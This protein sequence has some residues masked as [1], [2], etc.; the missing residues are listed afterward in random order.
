M[1]C[2]STLYLDRAVS[3]MPISTVASSTSSSSSITSVTTSAQSPTGIETSTST[4][5]RTTTQDSTSRSSSTT[6][7]NNTTTSNSRSTTSGSSQ[8][9][10][11][12]EPPFGVSNTTQGGL[13]S[14][15]SGTAEYK[16]KSVGDSTISSTSAGASITPSG[17]EQ[18]G[19][20]SPHHVSKTLAIAL[21][22]I[23]VAFSV[24]AALYYYKARKRRRLANLNVA[25]TT[26]V[27][28]DDPSTPPPALTQDSTRGSNGEAKSEPHVADDREP[29]TS[30]AEPW[31]PVPRQSIISSNSRSSP[32]RASTQRRDVL[33]PQNES[34]PSS[35]QASPY[36]PH[37]R[38][39][40]VSVPRPA[41]RTSPDVHQTPERDLR[42]RRLHPH[43]PPAS[44]SYDALIAAAEL[45]SRETA[46]A[47]GPSFQ[48]PAPSPQ[49]PV[50]AFE[51]RVVI[52]S[53]LSATGRNDQ[54]G[55]IVLPWPL[56]EQLLSFLASTPRSRGAVDESSTNLGSETLPAYAP[57]E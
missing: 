25:S 14:S 1:Y 19:S 3:S 47:P 7:S 31:L 23:P 46:V 54:D 9:P 11:T 49:P 10:A 43:N 20:S 22:I 18:S 15:T 2:R 55:A 41:A 8:P 5:P 40:T 6:T 45:A 33:A 4:S 13:S 36:D 26:C 30:D 32:R 42:Q 56:G 28:V 16:S 21:P 52:E 38:A 50:S 39:S 48:V 17:H 12:S 27:T 24:T 44:R 51:T 34:S 57:R 53:P 29:R 37:H 35:V